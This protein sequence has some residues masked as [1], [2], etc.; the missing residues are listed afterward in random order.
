MAINNSVLLPLP[1]DLGVEGVF[2]GIEVGPK[3][4]DRGGRFRVISEKDGGRKGG[5]KNGSDPNA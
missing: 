4:P 3:L 5:E 1:H 2:S